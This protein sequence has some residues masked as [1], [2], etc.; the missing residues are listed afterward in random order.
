MLDSLKK[1]TEPYMQQPASV[2]GSEE[3]QMSAAPPDSSIS[4]RL[5][6]VFLH[7]DILQHTGEH[8]SHEHYAALLQLHP[9]SCHFLWTCIIKYQLWKSKKL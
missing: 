6:S 5:Y 1:K 7:A 2:F 8:R 9:H 4:T 3:K